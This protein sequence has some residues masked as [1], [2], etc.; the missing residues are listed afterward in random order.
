MYANQ[1]QGIELYQALHEYDGA[2]A[3]ADLLE[4]WPGQC[5]DECWWLAEFSQRTGGGDDR[6]SDAT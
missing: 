2:A 3:Y 4:Q 1:M 5:P 6:R